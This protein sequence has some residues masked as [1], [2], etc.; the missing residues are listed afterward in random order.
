M[1]QQYVDDGI[2]TC[3]FAHNRVDKASPMVENVLGS[4]TAYIDADFPPSDAIDWDDHPTTFRSLDWVADSAS[5]QWRRLGNIFP[6][7]SGHSLFGT[8]IKPEDVKQG[9]IGN[10]WFIAAAAA[11]AEVPGR[12]EANWLTKTMNT[13]GV[14][15]LTMYVLGVPT[16]VVI[17]D[18]MP[19]YG[20]TYN[21][22]FAKVDKQGENTTWMALL[23]KAYAKVMGNY[24]QLIGGWASR[25]IDALTGY[26]SKTITNTSITATDLWNMLDE[27]DNRND[28]MSCSSHFDASGDV[29]TNAD[30]IAY[31][32]AYTLLGTETISLTDGTTEN[33]L[34]IR[35]PWKS[36]GYIGAWSDSDVK[37]NNVSATEKT[38]VGYDNNA[39]DGI[40][41]MSVASF[42]TNFHNFS[43][44]Y[45]L[46][47]W[48]HSHYLRVDDT[49]T[50]ITNPGS[51]Y[52]GGTTHTRHTMNIV[53]PVSQQVH[54]TAYIHDERS[55]PTDC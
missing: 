4:G 7:S 52:Y 15:A 36:E 1:A 33:L 45:D 40:F 54:V 38:R 55:Y 51:L 31:S 12:L 35:N 24:A 19:F 14:Y 16:T 42:Q 44:N 26:P 39:N 43:I 3:D 17:D 28:I 13:E 23:E 50:E 46:T 9:S 22:I 6:T 48:K 47:G 41:F 37:W 11:V 21:T 18:R 10:C 25:G 32:H 20:S 30:G 53:S 5:L 49:K 29:K 8:G 2:H 27:S 34:K